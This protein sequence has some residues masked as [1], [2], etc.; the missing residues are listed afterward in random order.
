[1]ASLS[2]VFKWQKICA[3][4]YAVA[5][6]VHILQ[7]Q[8]YL[9]DTAGLFVFS[10]LSPWLGTITI[11]GKLVSL[12]PHESAPGCTGATHVARVHRDSHESSL[13]P[14][15]GLLCYESRA[16]FATIS[17]SCKGGRREGK[18]EFQLAT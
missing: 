5:V 4:S 14:A 10:T 2:E 13:P 6:P 3:I 1:M 17:C 11:I 15:M 8:L 16:I 18:G 7:I 12:S 9:F